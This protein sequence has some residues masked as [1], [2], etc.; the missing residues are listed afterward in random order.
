MASG[1]Y[2]GAADVAGCVVGA[3]RAKS[4]FSKKKKKKKSLELVDCIALRG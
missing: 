3:D 4:Q 2:V 1:S